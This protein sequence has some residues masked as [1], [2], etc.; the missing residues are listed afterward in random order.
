L[1][2]VRAVLWFERAQNK[3]D[4]GVS[5]ENFYGTS[6]G[7]SWHHLLRR[8]LVRMDHHSSFIIHL[9]IIR[10]SSESPSS[11]LYTM[12]LPFRRPMGLQFPFQYLVARGDR[13]R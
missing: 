13:N 10:C 5:D 12:P 2:F 7:F 8:T 6:F 3:I 4:T 11:I 1:L 9:F